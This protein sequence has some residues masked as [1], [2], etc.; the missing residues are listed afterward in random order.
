M[1]RKV[2]VFTA[3]LGVLS[4]PAALYG[5]TAASSYA[6]DATGEA[7]VGIGLAYANGVDI[8]PDEEDNAYVLNL[9]IGYHFVDWFSLQFDFDA[10]DTDMETYMATARLWDRFYSTRPF[11][12]V[13]LG[14]IDAG[15]Y[16]TDLCAKLGLGM[17]Y[18]PYE[19][20]SFG[21]EIAYVTGFNDLDYIGYMT[22]ALGASLHF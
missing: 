5:W 8:T 20:I 17:E 7:Y 4:V 13:G 9:R 14:R 12:S 10:Y 1:V 16:G 15:D 19:N 18:F 3:F 2:L 21:S 11:L 6:P 22:V